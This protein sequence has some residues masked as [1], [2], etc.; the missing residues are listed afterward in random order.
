MQLIK[1]LVLVLYLNDFD[2]PAV[3]YDCCPDDGSSSSSG[4]WMTVGEASSA[5]SNG[6][7][8]A[9]GTAATVVLSEV[10]R[11]RIGPPY[12]NCV[13]QKYI[14]DQ[15]D[16]IIYSTPACQSLCL[17]KKVRNL[18]VKYR[19]DIPQSQ[20]RFLL[21]V[22]VLPYRVKIELH[23]KSDLS[24]GGKSIYGL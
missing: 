24:D 11:K 6:L 14:G 15:S 1:S 23:W 19:I 18:Q 12:G 2:Q 13:T 8:I 21:S 17:Q 9:P 3:K 22:S 16:N 20:T 5:T 10:D 7:S 4:I